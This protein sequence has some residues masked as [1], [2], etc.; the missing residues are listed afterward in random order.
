MSLPFGFVYDERMLEHECGYDP[1]M[2]ERPERMKLIYERLLND[3]LLED[4]IKVEARLATDKELILNHPEELIREIENLNTDEKCEEWCK[5]KEILW[6]SPK[7]EEASKLAA[8]GTIEMVKACLEGKISSGFAIVRPP[9]HHAYGKV[10]QGYCVFNNVAIAAKYA[11]EHLGLERVS[12]TLFFPLNGAMSTEGDFVAGFHNVL[13][14]ILKEWKPQLILISAGFDAGYY[15]V[16]LTLGQGVKAHGYGHMARLLS[17]ICPGRTLA[18]LEGGYFKTNYVEAASMMVRGLKGLPLPHSPVSKRVSGAFLETIWNN[19]IH[20]SK[21]YPVL[22]KTVE[23]L[24]ERQRAKGL[25]PFVQPEPLFLD[26]GMRKLYDEVKKLRCVRTREWFP[27]L[28]NEQVEISNALINEYIRNY[29]WKTETKPPTE[30]ELL[31]QLTWDEQAKFECYTMSAPTTMFFVNELKDFYEGKIDNTMICDRMLYAEAKSKQTFFVIALAQDPGEKD[32]VQN[33]PGLTFQPNFKTY[34]G[35]LNASADGKWKMFYVLHESKNN[36]STDPVL[37]W[38]NGGPGCSSLAGLLEELGPWYV[39]YDGQTLYENPFSWNLNASVLAIESPIGVGFSYSTDV[40]S[41]Y[42]AND[43]QTLEQNFQ[44]LTNFFKDVHPRFANHSFFL[45]GESYA[46]IYIPMLSKRLVEQI[47][48]NNFPNKNFQGAAIGNGFMNVRG[49]LNALALW[50]AYHG[51]ISMA[52][53]D[54]VKKTCANGNDVDSFDFSQYTYSSNKIDYLGN[55]SICG[56]IVQSLITQ[57]ANGTEGFDQYNFYYDCYDASLFQSPTPKLRRR[58]YFNGTKG[59]NP[60]TANLVNRV[61][62]DNQWGYFCWGDNAAALWANRR[63]VQDALHITQDWRNQ[64][65]GTYQWQD[66]NTDLYNNYTLTYDTTNQFFNYVLQNAATDFR[67]LIYNGDVDTVCNYL[68]DAKHINQVAKDNNLKAQCRQGNCFTDGDRIPWYFSDN[69]QL[70]GFYETF[71]GK[72]QKN[73]NTRIDLLTV[74]GAGHMV[75]FDR[76]GPS[77]QMIT[78][79]MF[80]DNKNNIDYTRKVIDSNPPLD[81]LRQRCTTRHLAPTR[82]R[83]INAVKAEPHQRKHFLSIW[84]NTKGS[85]YYE[86]LPA[87][88]AV[89][90][91]I[92]VDQLQKLV[93]I[94]RE[95]RPRHSI[96]HLL[97]D[98]ARPHVA[99]GTHQKTTKFD[100][101]PVIHSSYSPGLALPD[102]Y[103]FRP[104]RLHPRERKIDK[105]DDLKIAVDNFFASVS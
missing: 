21:H 8:G 102:Y 55:N 7:T 99:S 31:N 75:P 70:A 97:H 27:E 45:S 96:V 52:A 32:L 98:N 82:R 84:W 24:Q 4:A 63:D 65:N 92:Y 29:D 49:L 50:S 81:P 62:N 73:A 6:M 58:P 88:R 17:E 44:V 69:Q 89:T 86:L 94:I 93:G 71:T 19:L 15:D 14:P 59:L 20:H 60:N 79:F 61:S 56:N 13:I 68:G 77:V 10:P 66:C 101:H 72:N 90:A 11:V 40:E 95:K 22:G 100:W 64:K 16:M 33:L 43:D 47:N 54:Y 57:N 76:P 36:P 9:G 2:A 67:F 30:E 39:D 37:V 5:D 80:P 42:I 91:T 3:G 1:T 105:D 104:S 41:Y 74:K 87:S 103:L 85:I 53:W 28:S 83:A 26:R 23:K 46:G 18:V 35:Y 48:N 38:M 25:R 34:A 78:N 12:N 51:R